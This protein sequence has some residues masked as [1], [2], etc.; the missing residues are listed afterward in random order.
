MTS[1]AWKQNMK[2]NPTNLNLLVVYFSTYANPLYSTSY[3]RQIRQ[4]QILHIRPT[5]KW[6]YSCY[7]DLWPQ[8]PAP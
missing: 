4:I 3:L 1:L 7:I 2:I 6:S 5:R 8:C